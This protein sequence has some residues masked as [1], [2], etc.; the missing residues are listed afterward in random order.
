MS[1]TLDRLT[2]SINPLEMYHCSLKI[3][4]SSETQCSFC[5][6]DR[7]NK[8]IGCTNIA[9]KGFDYFYLE[10]GAEY[11]VKKYNDAKQVVKAERYRAKAREIIMDDNL[12]TVL[13]SENI[14][15]NSS[16]YTEAITKRIPNIQILNFYTKEEP[17]ETINKD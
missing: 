13:I 7:D 4:N 14:E 1:N 10:M 15:E 6:F 9:S 12:D 11:I 2:R 3:T 5:L 8:S 17:N 16:W